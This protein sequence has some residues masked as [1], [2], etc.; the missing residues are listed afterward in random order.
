MAGGTSSRR[1]LA[2]VVAVI[3]LVALAAV[4][5]LRVAYPPTVPRQLTIPERDCGLL[6]HFESLD[7]LKAHLG[8]SPSGWP[9]IFGDARI[10]GAGDVPAAGSTPH[11][12]T[13]NQVEG[14]D[15]ADIVK[16][17]DTYV[18]AAS[19]N[20]STYQSEVAIVRAYPPETAAL[21]ATI[22]VD[23]G[24]Q[25]LFLQGDRLAVITGGGYA[26][27]LDGGPRMPWFYRAQTRVLVYDVSDPATPALVENVTVSGNYVGSRMIGHVATLVVQDYLYLVDN[28]TSV[29]LPTI[30]TDGV[31][32]NLTYADIGYFADSEGSNAETIVL[33]IDLATPTPPSFESFLTRG[34]YQMYVSATN[35]YLGGVEWEANPDRTVV[36]ESTTVH[37]VSIDGAPHYVCSVRIPGTI[38]NQFSMDEASTVLRVATTLGQWTPEGRATSAAV[39]TFDDLLMNLGSLTG[40][41]PGER[42]FSA[43]FLGPRA[44]LVTYR[45]V[46]PL[47]VLDV[48]DPRAPRVLGFL[49]IPGVSDYL[50]P[51]DGTHL[52]GLGRD[53]PGGTGRLHGIKLSLF[54]VADVEHPAEVSSFVIGSAEAEWASSEAQFD[55]K[56]FLLVPDPALVVIPVTIYRWDGTSPSYWYGAYAVEVSPQG[57]FRLHGTIDHDAGNDSM[58]WSSQV[59]RSLTI[60]DV[61][62]TVSG[63]LVLGNRVDTLAEV[64]RVPL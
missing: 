4:G 11:S 33:S 14:V 21:V 52:I 36:A 48:S 35:L 44:Y 28:G 57:G 56:A 7:A 34:V 38:L 3:A 54:D 61:L 45:Q 30:W 64:A 60:G 6:N 55:H 16:S 32:R 42:V 9:W 31:P 25:G 1:K 22:P 53:D 37:K 17:D 59:R 15:E 27:I 13:N 29:V 12:G 24:V 19:W 62:Y 2:A 26:Y 46:D 10:L 5:L 58:Y 20:A 8:E 18:Y 63:S 51:L 50:H 23:P 47:F 49:K 40:L 41:A 43:R 39:F